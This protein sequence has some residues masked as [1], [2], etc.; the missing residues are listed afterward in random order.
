VRLSTVTF[1]IIYVMLLFLGCIPANSVKSETSER[2]RWIDDPQRLYPFEMYISAVGSGDTPEAAKNNAIAGVS[3]VF[4]ADIDA[5]RYLEETYFETGADKDMTLKKTSETINKI[6][7]TSD[8]SLKNIV[9]DKTWLSPTDARHY[10]LAYIDR[11]ETIAIYL[12]DI[13]AIDEEAAIFHNRYKEAGDDVT[14]MT[15]LAYINTSIDAAASRDVLIQQLNILSQGQGTY[16]PK[17]TPSDIILARDQARKNVRVKLELQQVE[18]PAFENSVREVLQSFG[19]GVVEENA[20]YILNG[21]FEIIRLEQTD[22]NRAFVRWNMDLHLN[23][24]AAQRQF[25]SY[26]DSGREGHTTY[27]E[28]ERRAART[29]RKSILDGFYTELE[30]Y[31]SSLT[32]K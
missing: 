5:R 9:I 3:Q 10:A 31:L 21:N 23:G 29:A 28:A 6:N 19:F 16:T 11:D 22:P 27:P 2:P 30:K 20:D 32:L 13:R 4:K 12:K 24:I 26:S 25:L 7:V 18:W 17:V 1:L 8:Q 14:P 15:K